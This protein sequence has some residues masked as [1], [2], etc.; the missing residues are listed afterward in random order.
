MF[1][2]MASSVVVFAAFGFQQRARS[3]RGRTPLVAPTLFTKRGFS[4]GLTFA[5]CFFAGM[6]GLLIVLMLHLQL[7][8]GYSSLHAGLTG[9]PFSLGAAVGA[10]VGAGLAPKL[11]RRVLIGGVIL[12]AGGLV[13]LSWT[14]NTAAGGLTTWDIAPSYAV[15]GVG[16]GVLIA[17]Y[18]TLVVAE[19]DEHETGTAGGVLNAVQQLANSLGVALFGTLYFNSLKA[20]HTS[21]A[22]ASSTLTYTAAAAAV[23][24]PLGLLLPRFARPDA[25]IH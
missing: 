12:M 15:C 20:G 18:Y 1:A 9:L 22:A 17:T 19:V 14:V 13:A 25:E 4:G 3:R 16:M 6:G 23:C 10:G 21:V 5:A 8:L 7:A 11:G 2:L 24:I